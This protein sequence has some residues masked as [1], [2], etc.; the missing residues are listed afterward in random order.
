MLMLFPS[1]PAPRRRQQRPASRQIRS[2]P[3]RALVHLGALLVMTGAT[4]GLLQAQQRPPVP[5]AR[6]PQDTTRPAPAPTP[7]T[8]TLAPVRIQGALTPAGL[9]APQS[10]LQRPV[11]R[12]QT[13]GAELPMALRQQPGVTI[14]SDA[15]SGFG[16]TYFRVRGFDQTRVATTLEG[17]PLSDPEDQGFFSS[18]LPNLAG[19]LGSA[20]L[21]N[22]VGGSSGGAA[23]IAGQ[24]N[25]TL[26]PALEGRHWGQVEQSLGAFG[27]RQTQLTLQTGIRPQGW[28]GWMTVTDQAADGWRDRARHD[29]RQGAAGLQWQGGQTQVRAAL[30]GGDVRHQMAWLATPWDLAR[31]APRTN[32]LPAGQGEH[33][34]QAL[35]LLQ[36]ER[37]TTSGQIWRA[38]VMQNE[39]DGNYDLSGATETETLNLRLRHSWS[40]AALTWASRAAEA[41]PTDGARVAR[42]LEAG[43][44]GSTF[45]RT[46]QLRL[47]PDLDAPLYDNRGHRQEVS[48]WGR[49]EQPLA[50]GWDGAAELQVRHSRFA[51]TPD[52]AA[53]AAGVIWPTA[54]WTFVNPRLRLGRPVGHAGLR[55]DVIA[56]QTTREPTRGDLFGGADDLDRPQLD[57]ILE[58]GLVQPERL[59]VLELRLQQPGRR[60][61]TP[62]GPPVLA[63]HTLATPG[64]SLTL[65]AGR[66]TNE[67]AAAGPLAPTGLP[68]RR[69]VPRSFRA[70][71]EGVWAAALGANTGVRMTGSVLQASFGTWVDEATADTVRSARPI[72]TPAVQGS[73]SVEQRLGRR[74]RVMLEGFAQGDQV[75][76]PRGAPQDRL[77]ALAWADLTLA[78]QQGPADISLTI[79]NLGDQFLPM[80]GWPDAAARPAVFPLAGRHVVARVRLPFGS[81][82]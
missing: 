52:A 16:Y 79:R 7:P 40:Q 51:Y 59:Q 19:V 64:W 15:G 1:R 76:S 28:A 32:L 39:L 57:L 24:L 81:L 2:G 44:L 9:A 4:A 77:P 73:L 29:G 62:A 69:N 65:H 47:R 35:G 41:A 10:T 46:H 38:T 78:H 74:T 34:Q 12:Q 71:V 70:G 80:T 8:Q 30:I 36:V 63:L 22:G 75:V 82:R 43:L 37:A 58:R 68:L 61:P 48:L 21:I 6:A 27:L 23:A 42:R 26:R 49:V 50:A 55:V 17:M 11:L 31:V 18:N 25:L 67:I 5:A 13:L 45:G 54:A 53:T 60:R 72:L 3:S 20:Q 66:M 33:F 56:A 14:S